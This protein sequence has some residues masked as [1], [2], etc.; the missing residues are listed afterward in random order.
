MIISESKKAI[1]IEVPGT[2]C[3]SI[4]KLFTP[5]L[6]EKHQSEKSIHVNDR[7]SSFSK[8]LPL[9]T[10]LEINSQD[11][12]KIIAVRNPYTRLID[13]WENYYKSPASNFNKT[14]ANNLR[15][16]FARHTGLN[17]FPSQE[18]HHMFPEGDFKSF[19]NFLDYILTKFSLDIARKYTGAADQYSY[20]E[21]DSWI[22]FDLILSFETLELNID[23]ISKKFNLEVCETFVSIEEQNRQEQARLLEYY[24]EESLKIVNR[25]FIRDFVYFK[26]S[27]L[28]F[29]DLKETKKVIS[30]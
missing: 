13:I 28:S 12:C 1:I 3:E 2:K 18:F 8:S 19:V 14:L 25:L 23:D 5:H 4:S 9:L 10:Q 16:T 30:A 15:F 29:F 27:K 22:E 11:Y 24:D 6:L 26:Y 21:N 17:P 20:I 7:F